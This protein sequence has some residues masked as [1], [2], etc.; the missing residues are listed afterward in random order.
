[1]KNSIDPLNII[2]EASFAEDSYLIERFL[3]KIKH[4]Y[5]YD[6][7]KDVLDFVVTRSREQILEFSV[8]E[9]KFF[10]MDE[11]NCHTIRAAVPQNILS[12]TLS[13][14]KSLILPSK[15]YKITIKKISCDVIIHEIGHMIEGELEGSFNG[16]EF[17]SLIQEDI[18]NINNFELKNTLNNVFIVEVSVY[19]EDQKTSELF[20]RYFQLLATSKEVGGAGSFTLTSFLA[21]FKDTTSYIQ[22]LIKDFIVPQSAEDIKSASKQ[23][24]SE[25]PKNTWSEQRVQSFHKIPGSSSWSKSIKSI[26]EDPFQ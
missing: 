26:K 15:K 13:S 1:M 16:Q 5:Q 12:R 8:K 19:P 23:Y 17:S 4:L 24:L 2:K 9:S 3:S 21:A 10:D 6:I 22:Q 11:G 18:N 25:K 7:F 20:A 14:L